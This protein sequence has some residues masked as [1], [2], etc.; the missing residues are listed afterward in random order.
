M[1]IF[2]FSFIVRLIDLLSLIQIY[3]IKKIAQEQIQ[4][5]NK[6]P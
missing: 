6:K 4:E 1:K 5:E 3:L 2:L